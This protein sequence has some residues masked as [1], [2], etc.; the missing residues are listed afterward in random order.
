MGLKEDNI[1]VVW[2]LRG[3][4]GLPL[5]PKLLAGK[6]KLDG[7]VCLGCVIK[8]IRATSTSNGAVS[9]GYAIVIGKW[10]MPV[11]LWEF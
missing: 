6:E 1:H 3:A 8:G 11:Y 7:V 2:S 9:N 5:G 4:F 10:Q